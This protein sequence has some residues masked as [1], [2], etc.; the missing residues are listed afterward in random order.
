M[1]NTTGKAK[2]D[3]NKAFGRTTCDLED[4]LLFELQPCFGNT[5]ITHR[6]GLPSYVPVWKVLL[7]LTITEA[8]S[9]GIFVLSYTN[10]GAYY[11]PLPTFWGG[12]QMLHMAI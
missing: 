10:I 1:M 2:E 12:S 8:L 5:G 7:I 6:M 4:V 11:C 3:V 9:G